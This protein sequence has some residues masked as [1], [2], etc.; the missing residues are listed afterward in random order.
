MELVVLIVGA[1]PAGLATAA[2]LSQRSIPYLIV[3]REDCSASLWRYR[4]Y[5]RVKLHLSKE[6]SCLPYMPHEEDTPTYIPKAEFLKYLDCYREHFGIKPRYCTCVVSAAY[7]EGTGRWVVAARDTVEGTEIRY[8]ARFLVVA[9]GENGAGRIPEIQGLESF[10]GEAIHSSTYKSGK[11]Y[12]GRRVLVVGAGNSGMEIAYDLA[13]HGADTSIVVRS[14]VHIMPKE[15]IRLGMT[16]VQYMPV[17]IVDL[18]LV[19]LADFIFG[20]LS[21][22]GI[23]RPGVGPLQLKSKTGRSSVIDVGTAGLI[24]KGVV[25]VFK[26][27]SKITGNKVQFE[28]GKDCE[29]DAI[30]FA[31]GYKSSANLWLK[32]DDKGMVNSDGRP[33][34]CRPNIWKGENG[35][36]FSGFRRMGLAGICMDAYNIAN[37][38]VSVY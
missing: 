24:K 27:I 26:R 30:V 29:F 9:T 35:L 20:D 36:Y 4:T 25:K 33:N 17:T 1:G 12:A 34:T 28:C 31:T 37:E 15:L 23:V 21:N 2:C 8:A 5:D 10:C 38:I 7:D 18:F 22:Y 16:F 13:N 11:S 3:E 14:P 19:K 6:F 32:A